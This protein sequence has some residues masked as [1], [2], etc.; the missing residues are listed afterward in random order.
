L[1]AR[2][3]QRSAPGAEH[4]SDRCGGWPASLRVAAAPLIGQW[5]M[6][7]PSG[8]SLDRSDDRLLIPTDLRWCAHGRGLLNGGSHRG[9]PAAALSGDLHHARP[10]RVLSRPA[11]GGVIA[12]GPLLLEWKAAFLSDP[13]SQRL[14]DQLR[15]PRR[16]V[17]MP[18]G[19]LP[20][21]SR[22][23]RDDPVPAIRAGRRRQVQLDRS[24]A[25]VQIAR[26]FARGDPVAPHPVGGRDALLQR[27]LERPQ[28][29]FTHTARLDRGLPRAKVRSRGRRARPA[30]VLT[31]PASGAPTANSVLVLSRRLPLGC[32]RRPA[33]LPPPIPKSGDNPLCAPRA[34]G[35]FARAAPIPR[36]H[37]ISHGLVHSSC[38]NQLH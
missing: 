33:E 1:V 31:R 22:S 15:C 5:W 37:R 25:D 34:G 32:P 2:G 7:V 38:G 10:A 12:R 9:A 11:A 6:A 19:A 17:G 28:P 29:P 26:D 30:R 23:W 14:H 21:T 24:R 35:H 13:C 3:L 4:S 27:Q 36:C 20:A 18:A 8:V 16:W